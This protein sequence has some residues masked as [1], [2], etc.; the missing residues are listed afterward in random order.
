MER[1]AHEGRCLHRNLRFQV[2]R[3]QLFVVD[4]SHKRFGSSKFLLLSSCVYANLVSDLFLFFL[5]VRNSSQLNWVID[6]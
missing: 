6:R 3:L 2:S 1:H 4:W 5:P